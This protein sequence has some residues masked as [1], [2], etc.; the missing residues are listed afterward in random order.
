MMYVALLLFLCG[1][2]SILLQDLEPNYPNPRIVIVGET[3][4]GKS[5]LANALL[6]CDPRSSDC[7]FGICS[8]T[9]SCTKETTIGTGPFVGS[10]ENF[11]VK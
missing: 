7:L 6:G 8:G 9:D 10:G 11:T 3:G 5:S 1:F 4:C 2:S